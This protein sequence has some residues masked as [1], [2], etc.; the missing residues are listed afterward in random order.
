M[1]N[2]SGNNTRKSGREN[3]IDCSRQI[4]FPA[5]I[6]KSESMASGNITLV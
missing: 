1:K 3:K 6:N 5:Y 4:G 2:N